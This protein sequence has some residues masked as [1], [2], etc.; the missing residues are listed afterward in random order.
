MTQNTGYALTVRNEYLQETCCQ[1]RLF[2]SIPAF[3]R[4]R[5]S[6]P[7]VNF[8]TCLCHPASHAKVEAW[9]IATLLSFPGSPQIAMASYAPAYVFIAGVCPDGLDSGLPAAHHQTVPARPD[10][11]SQVRNGYYSILQCIMVY[12]GV[13]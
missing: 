4:D 9:P 6:G 5:T 13:T 7:P 12:I 3:H 10:V 11:K 1:L 8:G 2:V